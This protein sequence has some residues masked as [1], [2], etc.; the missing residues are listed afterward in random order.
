LEVIAQIKTHSGIDV[1]RLLKDT[2]LKSNLAKE[3]KIALPKSGNAV[4]AHG[5]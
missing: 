2:S 5:N 3:K 1:A 4:G